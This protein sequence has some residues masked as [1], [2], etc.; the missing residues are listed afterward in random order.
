MVSSR[1][2]IARYS[3]FG[4]TFEILADSEKVREYKEGLLL[5]I[6]DVVI[7]TSIFKKITFAKKTDSGQLMQERAATADRV[8][9]ETL[10][11]VFGTS[12]FLEICKIILLEGEVQYT[13]EQ[14]NEFLE[15]KFKQ[16]ASIIASQ[17]ID[18]IRKVPH[19]Q[20]RIESVIKESR[21]KIDMY[22]S[23]ESQLKDVLKA[24]SIL[25]P[26]RMEVQTI[27]IMVGVQYG[28]AVKKIITDMTVLKNE[29]WTGSNYIATV[30]VGA[31]LVDTFYGKL[32]KITHGN[33]VSKVIE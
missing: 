21:V 18:P 5:D 13:I 2:V 30:S 1:Q 14:R 27:E 4:Q 11:K 7:S 22:K 31:G 8:D 12:D 10:I 19:P 23:A 17:A 6:Q 20:D 24:I 26:I 29:K 9:E 15:M 3:K 16:I 32:N 25:M 33:T 28:N